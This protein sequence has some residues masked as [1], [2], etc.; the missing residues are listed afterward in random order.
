LVGDIEGTFVGD[1]EICVVGVIVVDPVH[2]ALAG[3]PNPYPAFTP[4]IV[5][6]SN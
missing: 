3:T 2:V 6:K 4:S 5:S 1:N